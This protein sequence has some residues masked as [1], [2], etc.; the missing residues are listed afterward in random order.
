MY[1][2]QLKN[3]LQMKI[4]EGEKEERSILVNHIQ[5]TS[6]LCQHLILT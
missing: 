2:S 6:L 3:T 1:M 5:I 4:Y